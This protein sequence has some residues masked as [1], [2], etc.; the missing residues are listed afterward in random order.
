MEQLRAF[1]AM[2]GYG[3]FVW[4]AY[5]LTAAILIGLLVASMRRQRAV[6]SDLARLQDSETSAA[7][8]RTWR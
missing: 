3:D 5:A 2:G 1:L 4:P 6:R 7:D 8:A